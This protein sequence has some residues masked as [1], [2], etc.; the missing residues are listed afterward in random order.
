[1][2]ISLPLSSMQLLDRALTP[3]LKRRL[4]AVGVVPSG[5]A[6]KSFRFGMVRTVLKLQVEGGG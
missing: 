5:Y 2:S 3:I 6:Q 1:M 4:S